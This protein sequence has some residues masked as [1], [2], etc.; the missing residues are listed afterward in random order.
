MTLSAV[1]N[2]VSTHIALPD[3]SRL[4]ASCTTTQR[5]FKEEL[6]CVHVF[7]ESLE[8]IVHLPPPIISLCIHGTNERV[9]RIHGMHLLGITP[10]TH[11]RR[12]EIHL[13]KVYPQCLLVWCWLLEKKAGI[14]KSLQKKKGHVHVEVSKIH[15][16]PH[17]ITTRELPWWAD[18]LHRVFIQ[19]TNISIVI[20]GKNID[21]EMIEVYVLC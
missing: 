9:T 5:W 3:Q 21:K 4:A 12:I 17:G 14:L 15:N 20:D 1:C 19:Y 7:M 10:S 11:L 18:T 2:D 6:R 13:E 16:H 8:H